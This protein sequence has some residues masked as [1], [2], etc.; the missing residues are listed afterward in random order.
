MIKRILLSLSFVGLYAG[1]HEYMCTTVGNSNTPVRSIYNVLTID[2]A[3]V[4]DRSIIYKPISTI[5][6][7]NK[8]NNFLL[9]DLLQNLR[10][11]R[12]GLRT[13]RLSHQKQTPEFNSKRARL[14]SEAI[15]QIIR[16]EIFLSL[17]KLNFEQEKY[18]LCQ[19]CAAPKPID[20]IL[21]VDLNRLRHANVSWGEIKEHRRKF[22]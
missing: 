19:T 5:D 22:N 2:D 12:I 4:A 3:Q 8:N 17:P 15:K 10:S 6:L 11:V 1:Y 18:I 21:L 7:L 13:L 14:L 9:S 20:P 16:S